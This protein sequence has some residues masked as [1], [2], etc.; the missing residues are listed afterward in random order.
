MPSEARVA[1]DKLRKLRDTN[2]LK[3]LN[4]NQKQQVIECAINIIQYM[5]S[6]SN[7]KNT[8]DKILRRIDSY[9]YEIEATFGV[10]LEIRA[11]SIINSIA[12]DIR[13][14]VKTDQPKVKGHLGD[15]GTIGNDIRIT[16]GHTSE[17]ISNKYGNLDIG[18]LCQD[19]IIRYQYIKALRV[20]SK[21]R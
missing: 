7:D 20:F 15:N 19:P 9:I 10:N 11:R 21:H 16:S 8:T 1:R 18:F 6:L 2:A 3:K 13:S 4:G 14:N 5:Y 17:V 12:R